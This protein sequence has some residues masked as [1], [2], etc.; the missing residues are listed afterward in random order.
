MPL[1]VFVPNVEAK[2]VCRT[3]E[4]VY[5]RRKRAYNRGGGGGRTEG[6]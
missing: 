2:V 4:R 1:Q 6:V 5:D 3:G